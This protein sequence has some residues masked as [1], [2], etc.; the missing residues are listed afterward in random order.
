MR[1]LD[2]C[3]KRVDRQKL[4]RGDLIEINYLAS[5]AGTTWQEAKDYVRRQRSN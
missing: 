2:H 1:S 4:Q 5:L 3:V